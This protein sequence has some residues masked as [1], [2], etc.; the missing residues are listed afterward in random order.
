MTTAILDSWHW[1]AIFGPAIAIAG[2]V[3]LTIWDAY[4]A[5]GLIQAPRS[6]PIEDGEN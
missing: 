1:L 3:G 5:A 2:I 6:R 4:T